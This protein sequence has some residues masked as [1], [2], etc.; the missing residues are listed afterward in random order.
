[1]GSWLMGREAVGMAGA[2]ERVGIWA[3]GR[4]G[5]VVGEEEAEEISAMEEGRGINDVVDEKVLEVQRWWVRW[6]GIRGVGVDLLGVGLFGW[7]AVR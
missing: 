6:C 2:Y 4:G 5:K 7:V 1:M 3:E